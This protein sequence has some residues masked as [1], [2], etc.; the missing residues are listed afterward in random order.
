MAAARSMW[1]AICLGAHL[2]A[3]LA[4]AT[5]D[6]RTAA[7]SRR[8]CA[9][10]HG[11]CVEATS[12]RPSDRRL[13]TSSSTAGHRSQRSRRFLPSDTLLM[14]AADRAPTLQPIG[15]SLMGC[16]CETYI[17]AVP[18]TAAPIGHTGVSSDPRPTYV[19]LT[20]PSS[21]IAL[22]SVAFTSTARPIHW[23]R[24]SCLLCTGPLSTPILRIPPCTRLHRMCNAVPK[25]SP[26]LTYSAFY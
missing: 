22:V 14:L 11:I 13:T 18:L 7:V 23:L 3:L 9:L 17:D 12:Y 8:F 21:H 10:A 15:C 4:Q 25:L 19:K 2:A 24:L 1:V 20:W 5:G 16:D 6:A 26:S